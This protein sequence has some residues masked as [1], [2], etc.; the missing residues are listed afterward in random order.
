MNMPSSR[1]PVPV[2]AVALLL[3]LPAA[4]CPAASAASH[5]PYPLGSARHCRAH[6]Y[7]RFR[8]HTVDGK[9]VR[10]IACVWGTGPGPTTTV[11]A[12]TTTTTAPGFVA[13][14]V[15][16]IGD[17]VMLDAAPDLAADIPGIDIE[18]EVSRQWDAGV[19]LAAQLKA[20]DKLGATVVIDLGTNGPITDSQFQAMMAVLAKA[21]LVVFVTVHL[22]PSYS[23]SQSVNAV[24]EQ[25][26]PKYAN[27]RLANFNALA[28]ANPDWFGS[29]GVHMVI[30]GI[31]AKAMAK[32][33]TSTIKG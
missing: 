16:A 2:L 6:Y 33:I 31:G 15:T 8:F 18:T 4:T 26:V 23:W 22:P 32:L 11:P 1:K 10:Y 20:E 19:A 5:P 9:K 25:E 24:L 28:D 29:D 27:A 30:G 12:T 13:G 21:S 17:S 14:H 3:A 7:K